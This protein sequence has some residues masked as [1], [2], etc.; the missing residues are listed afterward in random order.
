MH[1]IKREMDEFI[2]STRTKFII[3]GKN[4]IIAVYYNN[5]PP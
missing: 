5:M 2:Q 4:K 3:Q 1:I